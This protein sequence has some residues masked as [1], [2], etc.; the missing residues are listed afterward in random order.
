MDG[1]HTI[2]MFLC[3]AALACGTPDPSVPTPSPSPTDTPVPP[4]L[5]I[6]VIVPPAG[7]PDPFENLATY[8]VT[9][10]ASGT[11]VLSETF[12][13][14]DPVEIP[15]LDPAVDTRVILEGL[16]AGDTVLSRG[17]TRLFD[18]TDED[19]QVA[20][21]YFAKIGTFARI[22]GPVA[23]RTAPY[24]L[25]LSDQHVLVGGGMVN[26]DPVDTAVVYDPDTDTTTDVDNAPSNHAYAHTEVLSKDTMLVLGGLGG[27][28]PTDNVSVAVYD[29]S[30]VS[31]SWSALP[32]M[33]D[34]R[35]YFMSARLSPTQVFVGGGEDGGG[36][37]NST[38]VLTWDGTDGTWEDG[39]NLEDRKQAGV[40]AVVLEGKAVVGLGLTN[41]GNYDND[42]ELYEY[43]PGGGGTAGSLSALGQ[44]TD[45][46]HVFHVYMDDGSVL[47]M[48][49]FDDQNQPVDVVEQLVYDDGGPTLTAMP[50]NPLPTAGTIGGA[51]RQADG[52][53]LLV[54]GDAGT[55]G[56]PVAIDQALVFD[57]VGDSYTDFE[58]SPG[59][60][61]HAFVT[62]LPDDTMLFV[63]DG[64]ILRYNPLP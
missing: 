48:G 50:R 43:S 42:I 24:V 7:E 13:V 11:E 32:D 23:G 28:N 33:T 19:G 39:P 3:A 17:Q 61:T 45:R 38:E 25:V 16:D 51:Y 41:P 57:P 53:W 14:G 52:T 37:V 6:E 30:T 20:Y 56:S 21:L 2:A 46:S 49:G 18:L 5:T 62:V 59:A 29:P 15:G 22:N 40:G 9:I 26:G 10:L 36:S 64:T 31:V 4:Q 63:V 1:R 54:G 55:P 35:L 27:N 8:R 12:A 34:R 44:F 60:T 58:A 47:S